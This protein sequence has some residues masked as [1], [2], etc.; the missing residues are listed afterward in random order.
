[1]TTVAAG[2]KSRLATFCSLPSTLTQAV[3]EATAATGEGVFETL[4][5]VAR[6]VLVELKKG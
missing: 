1:M 2:L 3:L 4:K 5:E 6:Q